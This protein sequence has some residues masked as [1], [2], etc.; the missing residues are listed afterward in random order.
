LKKTGRG[1]AGGANGDAT[2]DAA[3]NDDL[4]DVFQLRNDL[5]GTLRNPRV[6]GK[7]TVVERLV[8]EIGAQLIEY[9]YSEVF[10]LPGLVRLTAK[11][12]EKAGM[13][14]ALARVA[15][16]WA[17]GHDPRIAEMLKP[18]KKGRKGGGTDALPLAPPMPNPDESAEGE[19]SI[20]QIDRNG[21]VRPNEANFRTAMDRLGI[22]L[23]YDLFAREIRL[24]GLDGY[25]PG[26]DKDTVS[27][28]YLKIQ[29]EFYFRIG[30]DDLERML[31]IAARDNAF[32][33]ITDY[34]SGLVWDGVERLDEWLI[35]YGGAKDDAYVREVGAKFLIAAVR[36]A[37]QPG[38]KFDYMPIFEGDEG[39]GK[40]SVGAILAG[41]A[42]FTDSIPIH[43]HEPRH[44]IE[45][46]RG[47]WICE[48]AELASI[49]RT[50]DVET[51]KAWLSRSTDTAALKWERDSTGVPRRFVVFGTTN[52]DGTGYFDQRT[53]NRRFWPIRV[54]GF[55]LE[56]VARDR[57]NLW[58]EAVWRER[59]GESLEISPD[60]KSL[61]KV[62]QEAREVTDA[63]EDL[64]AEWAAVTYDQEFLKSTAP[65][66]VQG[67]MA[68]IAEVV[69]RIEPSRLTRP[70]QLRIGV[71]LTRLGF[72]KEH[73]RNGKIWK[74]VKY[75]L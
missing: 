62:E 19:S 4:L 26:L 49:K 39:R 74:K 10:D 33:P 45:A 31:R 30:F 55:D 70:D 61:A 32:D 66:I 6:R 3:P 36:R 44:T 9:C 57:D 67:P 65:R 38:C 13:E 54:D 59:A 71:A 47:K 18:K 43:S 21:K 7:I 20:W 48:A 25:G 52:P 60:V 41:A 2:L 73:T 53:G 37:F 11:E 42:Y 58:A 17:V 16:L 28:L 14:N 69:L 50:Q 40:S 46:L 23:S 68:R 24:D 34:L 29:S 75:E 22:R 51:V 35:T 56:A 63:W 27:K 8:A 15:E 64:L 5:L 12:A 72:K 1:G